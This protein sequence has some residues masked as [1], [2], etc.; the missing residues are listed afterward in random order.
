MTTVI[1]ES[2]APGGTGTLIE[3]VGTESAYIYNVAI[4]PLS[5]MALCYVLLIPHQECNVLAPTYSHYTCHNAISLHTSTRSH[6]PSNVKVKDFF[7][8]HP[9]R[10]AGDRGYRQGVEHIRENIAWLR[11]NLDLLSSCLN[12]IEDCFRSSV[13]S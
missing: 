5:S 2:C 4:G 3:L 10:G 6:S 1:T 13:I 12:N 9:N 7:H 8:Q 11:T